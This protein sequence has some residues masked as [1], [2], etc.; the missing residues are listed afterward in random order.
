MLGADPHRTAQIEGLMH[1]TD[2][3]RFHHL[4]DR[5]PQTGLSNQRGQG[6]VG[7]D[8]QS[9]RISGLL[10]LRCGLP[11]EIALFVS[12]E[13]NAVVV[14]RHQAGCRHVRQQWARLMKQRLAAGPPGDSIAFSRTDDQLP[15]LKEQRSPQP[16]DVDQPLNPQPQTLARISPLRLL[17]N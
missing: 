4:M 12:M 11:T 14:R 9:H 10:S 6:L 3:Q 7:P 13:S 5:I 2:Q 17:N 1:G 8:A 16:A 15:G